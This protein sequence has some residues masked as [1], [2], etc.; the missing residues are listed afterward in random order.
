MNIIKQ[1]RDTL[2]EAHESGDKRIIK[3]LHA[4]DLEA[5]LDVVEAAKKHCTIIG[6]SIT[7]AREFN[8]WSDLDDALQRLEDIDK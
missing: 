4:D 8:S 7:S 6:E 1:L 5:L 3:I 2:K